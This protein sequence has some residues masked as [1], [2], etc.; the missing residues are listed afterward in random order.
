MIICLES[1]SLPSDSAL[2]QG[3]FAL[4]H[5]APGVSSDFSNPLSN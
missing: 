3:I 4:A 5:R 2:Y 1:E